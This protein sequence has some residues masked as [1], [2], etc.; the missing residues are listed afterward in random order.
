MNRRV[1]VTLALGMT[2]V[3]CNEVLVGQW[4][5]ESTRPPEAKDRYE[6]QAVTFHPDAATFE[7]SVQREGKITKSAGEYSYN[8]FNLSL[9]LKDGKKLSYSATYNSFTRK[10]EVRG[11]APGPEGEADQKITA[12]Y[13]RVRP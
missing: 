11:T 2:L 7:A 9:T 1:L 3:G 10:L 4:N 5:L 13:R 12:V 6:I 8:G